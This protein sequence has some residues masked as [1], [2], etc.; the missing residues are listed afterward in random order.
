MAGE[1]LVALKRYD[2]VEEIIP[3]LEEVAKPGMRVV[4]LLRYP[5]HSSNYFS[6]HWI[7][8]ESRTKAALE[9]R[10]V[11]ERYSWRR[12][13]ELAERKLLAAREAFRKMGVETAVEIYAGSLRRVVS[14]YA[15]KENSYLIVTQTRKCFPLMRFLLKMIFPFGL[16]QTR[17][18]FPAVLVH[19]NR[20]T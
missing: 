16:D 3:Y 4:F 15:A 18:F 17:H 20:R 12:Q 13:K 11:I 5:V 10:K 19:L 7:T 6:D 8:T 1:I 2:R 9:G 14:D